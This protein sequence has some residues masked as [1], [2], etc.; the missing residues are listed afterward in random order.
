MQLSFETDRLIALE[1]IVQQM[2]ATSS[3]GDYVAGMWTH[4]LERQV[5][6][7]LQDTFTKTVT[8]MAPSWSWASNNGSVFFADAGNFTMTEAPKGDA[9]QIESVT[10]FDPSE[11]VSGVLR[12]RSKALEMTA[13]VVRPSSSQAPAAYELK[14]NKHGQLRLHV[15]TDL[16]DSDDV[17]GRR[18]TLVVLWWG[19]T[20][21]GW[22]YFLILQPAVVAGVYYRRFG[23]LSFALN[24]PDGSQK[25]ANILAHSKEQ[26]FNIIYSRTSAERAPKAE[27]QMSTHSSQVAGH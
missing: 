8:R 24:A 20:W 3:V 4:R 1:G 5:T 10:A 18:R 17:L 27:P 9:A 16:I 6:W 21:G 15:C 23:N 14:D 2:R 22:A 19:Q 26:A 11:E 25:L 13:T 12:V 7:F